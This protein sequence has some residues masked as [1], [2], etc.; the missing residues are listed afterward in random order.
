MAR[1]LWTGWLS[2]GLVN[3]PVEVHTAVRDHR[4][5]FRMLHAKDL[6]PVKFERVC[7]KD[8]KPVAWNDLVKGYEYASGHFVVLTKDDF[9]AAALEKNRR[10]DIMHFVDAHE[11]DDRYFETPYYLLPSKGGEEA[12]ALLREAL[13]DTSR[14]GIAKFIMR[15]TQHLVAIEP[16]DEAIVLSLMRFSDELAD[17]PTVSLPKRATLGKAELDTAKMLVNALAAEWDPGKY[18][19]EYVENLMKI[20]HAKQKGKAVALEAPAEK[21]RTNVVNLMDRLRES[22]NA[23]QQGGKAAKPA[24]KGTTA[25]A[26]KRST[27]SA[28]GKRKTR[29]A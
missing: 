29:A 12:Y 20:I 15:D 26:A 1:S 11:I 25:K 2:F 7:I 16:I 28:K 14:I 18:T 23:V 27:T 24:V 9:K 21:P 13:R 19:D 8:G 5:H 22:L 4:P 3:I 17:T 6:S 10:I